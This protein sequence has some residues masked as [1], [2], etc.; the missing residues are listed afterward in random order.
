MQNIQIQTAK[1]YRKMAEI[2]NESQYEALIQRIEE[3]LMVVSNETPITD[4]N[5][6]ELD[7]ISN[8]VEEYEEKYYPVKMPTLPEVIREEMTERGLSQKE[9]AEL[10]GVSPP[11]ISEYMNGKSEPTLKVARLLHRKLDIDPDILLS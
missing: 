5:Y 7:V 11:R 3:L 2:N 8:L 9:L 6:I 4:R 10:L 1:T